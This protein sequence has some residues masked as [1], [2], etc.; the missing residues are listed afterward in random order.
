MSGDLL[1]LVITQFAVFIP[2]TIL[3]ST[4]LHDDIGATLKMIGRQ[5]TL[6]RIDPAPGNTGTARQGQHCWT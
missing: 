6:T 3:R 2:D 4:D 5:A 1:E